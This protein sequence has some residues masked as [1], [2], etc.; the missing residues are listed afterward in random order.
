MTGAALSGR[1]QRRVNDALR[2]LQD[3]AQML[4]AAKTLA[5]D[6]VDILGTRR[7][8]GEPAAG[9]D[10]LDAADGRIIARCAVQNALDLLP[11]QLRRVHLLRRELRQ[12]LFLVGRCRGLNPI[13]GR[14][15]EALREIDIVL[16]RIAS[17]A[18]GDF[19]GQQGRDDAVLVGRPDAA[20]Q[21]V[22]SRP[23]ALLAAKAQPAL[24]QAIDEPFK[25]DRDLVET[26][27]QLGGDTIDHGAAHDGLADRG[28]WT[29][30]RALT[31]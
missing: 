9:R 27:T 2:L 22:E 12:P 23:G 31:I 5:I 17:R 18:R 19:R 20:V 26:A 3:R 21:P 4:L 11:R 6:L 13:G 29:P 28:G 8:G 25:A 30:V 10:H 15:A 1:L 16:A 14:L 24:D 7:P